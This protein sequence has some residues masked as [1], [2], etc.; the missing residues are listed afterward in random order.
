MT[1]AERKENKNQTSSITFQQKNQIEPQEI[2]AMSEWHFKNTSRNKFG[3]NLQTWNY[4]VALNPSLM[5]L[6]NCQLTSHSL[7]MVSAI[8]C[9]TE[10]NV[11]PDEHPFPIQITHP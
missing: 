2:Y 3:L 8:K 11:V 4:F 7:K 1:K 5:S 6:L 9:I 10:E